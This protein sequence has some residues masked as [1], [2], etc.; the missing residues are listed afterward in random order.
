MRKRY[1]NL[2]FAWGACCV[3]GGT[4]M[5][6]PII[7]VFTIHSGSV[8]DID[9]GES[10][11]T[12][13]RPHERFDFEFIVENVGDG[14]LGTDRIEA[15]FSDD[16]PGRR[17]GHSSNPDGFVG[18]VGFLPD[19]IGP[20]AID[21]S[22]F[23]NLPD[24]PF[25]FTIE[26]FIRDPILLLSHNGAFVSSEEP[27]TLAS[28]GV[29]ESVA[30]VIE[31]KNSGNAFLEFGSQPTIV[32]MTGNGDG[33]E[34]TLTHPQYVQHETA[35]DLF[36]EFRPQ[37]DGARAFLVTLPS[38]ATDSP[39]EFVIEAQVLPSFPDCNA[40]DIDDFDDIGLGTSMDCDRNEEPDECQGD[41]DGDGVIDPCDA[42]PGED[43]LLD[44]DGD[45]VADCLDNCPDIPN[46]DQLDSN[47]DG[48]GDACDA[49]EPEPPIDEDPE[50]SDC[51][52]NGTDDID[53]VDDGS[54]ADCNRNDVPDECESDSDGD[55]VIDG[56]DRC[57]GEDD[58]VDRDD[59]S[60]PDCVDNCPEV[61]N[62]SQT[63]SDSDGVGDACEEI[64]GRDVDNADP[65]PD[66]GETP[67]VDVAT[68]FCG[69]GIATFMPFSMFGLIG[70][71]S[72]RRPLP[73]RSRR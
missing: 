46:E 40:N 20:F 42:C 54:S 31:A 25:E 4:A 70:L 18:H 8:Q 12:F 26:G 13:A 39:H 2:L 68:Q 47:G 41:S 10:V 35:V 65:S 34:L 30:A 51:N 69:T 23:T 48:V 33:S 45:L 73:A 5:A 57:P 50:I 37:S 67:E 32:E 72:R 52:E 38:N 9:P 22:V 36:V 53:D 1:V 17:S 49:G 19:E 71:R 55:G 62:A 14:F 63:D 44:S 28:V 27:I 60:V 58:A 29:G 56:C 43:D 24:S 6:D 59:D 11:L 16:L 21:V 3:F 15:T 66:D 7:R 64:A 61:A